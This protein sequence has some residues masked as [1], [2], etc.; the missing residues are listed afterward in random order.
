MMKCPQCDFEN[1]EG[2]K[3]CKNCNVL[4]S[5]LDYSEENPYLKKNIDEIEEEKVGKKIRAGVKTKITVLVLLIILAS[6]AGFFMF[7]PYIS[8]IKEA[9]DLDASVKFTGT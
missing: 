1:E 6:I 7:K 2:S 3:F 5:K 8:Q 9:T 4:L